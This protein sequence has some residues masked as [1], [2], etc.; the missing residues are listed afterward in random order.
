MAKCCSANKGGGLMPEL[1]PNDIS[2][3]VFIRS[4]D[5]N[6]FMDTMSHLVK[7]NTE[8]LGTAT[9]NTFVFTFDNETE[10]MPIEVVDG[11]IINSDD[12]IYQELHRKPID[13]NYTFEDYERLLQKMLIVD[14][15]ESVYHIKGAEVPFFYRVL[16]SL[17]TKTRRT[18]E[19]PLTMIEAMS[20]L[21]SPSLLS[22]SLG[23]HHF[24]ALKKGLR[25]WQKDTQDKE[26]YAK[27]ISLAQFIFNMNRG[28]GWIYLL[29][30][31]L[32]EI[33]L[34][35]SELRQ[36][37]I[38]EEKYSAKRTSSSR[39]E[40]YLEQSD[41]N[42]LEMAQSMTSGIKTFGD[43]R[44]ELQSKDYDIVSTKFVQPTT[45]VK[46]DILKDK[47]YEEAMGL[48][49][50]IEK[51]S[52]LVKLFNK[53]Q[54][55]IEQDR[56]WTSDVEMLRKEIKDHK[57]LGN[58]NVVEFISKIVNQIIDAGLVKIRTYDKRTDRITT[59]QRK[60]MWEQSGKRLIALT[61][62][63]YIELEDLLGITK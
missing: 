33:R 26:R 31:A 34:F 4:E 53:S 46:L 54:K 36:S 7:E 35:G 8:M 55:E 39:K 61:N 57:A 3:E 43:F 16:R 21:F 19:L 17:I 62:D 25:V 40:Q 45:D 9:S 44:K 12:I 22:T 50:F 49:D 14:C 20:V 28:V 41:Q 27:P 24:K 63:R 29:N 58:E 47:S 37:D 48:V 6:I 18:Y 38:P 60:K 10:R 59:Q 30:T 11:H 2:D 13:D 56:T 42:I 52:S 51:F 15:W 32:Q 1:R 5:Y 23:P